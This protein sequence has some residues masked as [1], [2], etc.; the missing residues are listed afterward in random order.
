MVKREIF[1]LFSW[2]LFSQLVGCSSDEH[3]AIGDPD[4]NR[5]TT[6]KGYTVV[7][8]PGG[9]VDYRYNQIKRQYQQPVHNRIRETVYF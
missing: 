1:A 4:G 3:F 2:L 5:V 8:S 9:E 6:G 7:E